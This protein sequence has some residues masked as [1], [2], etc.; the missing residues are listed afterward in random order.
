MGK[1]GGSGA[2]VMAAKASGSGGWEVVKRG[3]RPVANSG[4]RGGGG[5]R[6]ALGEANGGWK[7]DLSCEYSPPPTWACG[8]GT[9]WSSCGSRERIRGAPATLADSAGRGGH[10]HCTSGSGGPAKHT[11]ESEKTGITISI[12]SGLCTQPS[13]LSRPSLARFLSDEAEASGILRGAPC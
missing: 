6:R 10:P 9:R 12:C 7:Y 4:G 13:Q 1:S 11:L 2:G 5:D 3:R 8:S